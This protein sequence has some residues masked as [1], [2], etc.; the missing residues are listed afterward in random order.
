MDD[1]RHNN[2]VSSVFVDTCKRML[3][4]KKLFD[5]EPVNQEHVHNESYQNQFSII[6]KKLTSDD[7]GMKL[8]KMMTVM[9]T[10]HKNSTLIDKRKY[11]DMI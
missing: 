6:D 2:P 7:R 8:V 4:R 3:R 10:V 1:H 11:I 9:F 5:E